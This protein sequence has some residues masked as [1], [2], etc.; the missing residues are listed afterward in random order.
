MFASE[1]RLVILFL[2]LDAWLAF[3]SSLVANVFR[4]LLSA[5][6]TTN[7]SPEGVYGVAEDVRGIFP[8]DISGRIEYVVA[9]E[10]VV[11]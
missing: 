8:V 7:L 5:F 3:I 4:S 6:I 10:F 2:G 1:L 9:L 11:E